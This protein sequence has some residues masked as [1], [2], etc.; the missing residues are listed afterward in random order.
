MPRDVVRKRVVIATRNDPDE[1]YLSGWTG[2]FDGYYLKELRMKR[3]RQIGFKVAN[4]TALESTYAIPE[5]VAF[6]RER[7]WKVQTNYT[8]RPGAVNTG[9]ND[10]FAETKDKSVL[11]RTPCFANPNYIAKSTNDFVTAA[12]QL[13]VARL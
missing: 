6:W 4:V 5:G 13:A 2:R 10:R 9:Y 12:R 11:V 1:F 8:I 7:G 3:L